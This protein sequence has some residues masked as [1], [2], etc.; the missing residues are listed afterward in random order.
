MDVDVD[1]DLCIGAARC[2]RYAPTVFTQDDDGVAALLPDGV[3]QEDGADVSLAARA[4]PVRA[5]RLR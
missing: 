4:C 3:R 5:I 2:V 1:R